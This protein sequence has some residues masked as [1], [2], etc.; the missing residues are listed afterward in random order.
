MGIEIGDP[1]RPARSFILAL[2]IMFVAAP[3]LIRSI[4]RIKVVDP[5]KEAVAPH[6]PTATV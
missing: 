2:V 6:Q 5:A 1:V 3:D 4:W